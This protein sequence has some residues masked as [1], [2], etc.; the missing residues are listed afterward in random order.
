MKKMEA[1]QMEA[2]VGGANSFW[3]GVACGLMVG[4]GAILGGLGGASAGSL[5]G[6]GGTLAGGIGGAYVGGAVGV[7]YCILAV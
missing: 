5:L 4:G 7:G 3:T 2:V 1:K 6:P